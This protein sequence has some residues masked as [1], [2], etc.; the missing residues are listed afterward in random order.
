MKAELGVTTFVTE[1]AEDSY[2][3]VPVD[4]RSPSPDNSFSAGFWC[5][6]IVVR[7][8]LLRLLAVWQ[9]SGNIVSERL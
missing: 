6:R 2:E 5:N 3:F 1:P 4:L 7:A 8:L 9:L